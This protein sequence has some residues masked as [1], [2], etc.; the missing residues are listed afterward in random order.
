[1]MKRIASAFLAL[2]ILVSALPLGATATPVRETEI[3]ETVRLPA[4]EEPGKGWEP[5]GENWCIR[6]NALSTTNWFA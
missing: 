5:D 1:M 4:K 3:G 6:K 2:L